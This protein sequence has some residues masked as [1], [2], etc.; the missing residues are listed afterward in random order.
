MVDV[1]MRYDKVLDRLSR[2]LLFDS[3]DNGDRPF[4]EKRRFDHDHMVLHFNGHAVMI[5]TFDVIDALRNL[6]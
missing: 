1:E 6:D 4:F 3:F 5:A 2:N